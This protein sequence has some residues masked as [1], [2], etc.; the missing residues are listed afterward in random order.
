MVPKNL[1]FYVMN[2]VEE[3]GRDEVI[4]TGD[5]TVIGSGIRER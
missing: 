2:V 4:K 5:D 1:A 3:K